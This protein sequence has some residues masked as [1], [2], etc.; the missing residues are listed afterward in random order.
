MRRALREA[1]RLNIDPNKL[2]ED[3][4]DTPALVEVAR[5]GIVDAMQLPSLRAPTAS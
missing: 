4:F 2:T 1:S 5:Q 3:E